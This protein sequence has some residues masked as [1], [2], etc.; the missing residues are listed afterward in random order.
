[1]IKFSTLKKNSWPYLAVAVV[2][3]AGVFFG[4]SAFYQPVAKADSTSVDSSAEKGKSVST[5]PRII[6]AM[7][8]SMY[9][10]VADDEDIK[11]MAQWIKN[12]AKNDDTFKKDIYPI[13]K[14]DCVNCHS[15]TSTMTKKMPH[16]PF[17]SYE[18]VKKLTKVG[19]DDSSCLECHGN[20]ILKNRP[21]E[22]FKSQFVDQAKLKT[23]VHKKLRCIR[24]HVVLHPETDNIYQDTKAFE[25]HVL[26]G[27]TV[28]ESG[29]TQIFKPDCANCHPK[30]GVKLAKSSHSA[31]KLEIKLAR[32]D[33]STQVALKNQTELRAP[34]C[35]DCHGTQQHY[36]TDTKLNQT[37]FDVVNRCGTCH[38]KLIDT[39]FSTYHGQAA[40]L[41]SDRVAKCANCHGTHD[42]LSSSNPASTLHAKNILKTC[43]E[44]HPK[45]GKKFT[46][47]L[48]HADNQDRE[49]NPLLFY[50][51]WGMTLIIVFTF[52]LFGT[53]SILWLNRS[54]IEGL[55]ARKNKAKTIVPDKKKKRHIR[56][57]KT[58]HSILHLMIIVSFLTLALTGMALKFADNPVFAFVNEAVGGP[59]VMG[60]IHMIGALITLLYVSIHFFQ[61]AVLCIKRKITFK[62]LC[63]EEYSLILLPRDF[64]D[65]KANVLY[66]VGKGPKPEFGRWTYWEKFDYLA[67]LWGTVI[68]GTTGLMLAFPEF[69]TQFLPGVA[70]NIATIIHTFE[71]LLATGFIFS[72][73]FFNSHIRPEI[74]PM[75]TAI[76]TQRLSLPRFKEER[77]REYMELV[78]NGEL[79]KYLANPPGKWYSGIAAI[80]GWF[81]LTIGIITLGAIIYSLLILIFI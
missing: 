2:I 5:E 55:S 79:D 4:I 8:T 76:F 14:N 43:Q 36:I 28:A 68:I 81:F 10:Q 40:K 11:I 18:D 29:R 62:G 6:A 35:N 77:P 19:P 30:V 47:F 67:E 3:S 46:G 63:K 38:E 60:K 20:L 9:E 21:D 65:L 39:Y 41:G 12:G 74:F 7:K 61:L 26:K 78:R 22:K 48:P 32:P 13:I 51:F 44:C 75:D 50:I 52:A 49:K 57:F 37:K 73:H 45:A 59:H 15:R 42:L 17:A 34:K 58:S 80:M 53:H 71:A 64:K 54:V 23:S 66:F 70:L 56:R 72:I 24:C 69:T 16:I 33:Q 25:A 1:M 27:K 31:K